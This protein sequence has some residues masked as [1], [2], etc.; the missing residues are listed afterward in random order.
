M[1]IRLILEEIKQKL[2]DASHRRFTGEI[3]L[4]FNVS[5][6]GFGTIYMEKER[7]NLIRKKAG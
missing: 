5:Q 7:E 6:G 1:E 2:R 4:T 3:R